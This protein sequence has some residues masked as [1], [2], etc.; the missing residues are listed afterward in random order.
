MNTTFPCSTFAPRGFASV[1]GKRH[2]SKTDAHW[3]S[4]AA[5]V[6]VADAHLL[7]A[8]LPLH[9]LRACALWFLLYRVR[10]ENG[11]H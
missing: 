5:A 11:G 9:T 6:S 1:T 2:T 3:H 10:P 7:G 4:F 8:K